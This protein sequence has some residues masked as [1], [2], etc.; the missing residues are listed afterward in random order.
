MLKYYYDLNRETPVHLIMDECCKTL[1]I[2]PDEPLS[3]EKTAELKALI[4]YRLGHYSLGLPY[5]E[6][7]T[8]EEFANILQK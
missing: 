2:A 4:T 5:V 7:I 8:P 3:A 6:T 1:G